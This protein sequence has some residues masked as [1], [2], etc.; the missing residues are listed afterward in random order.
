MVVVLF[1]QCSPLNLNFSPW[2]K[3]RPVSVRQQ[4]EGLKGAKVVP[5]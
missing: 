3:G 4:L 1:L 5:G 2:S